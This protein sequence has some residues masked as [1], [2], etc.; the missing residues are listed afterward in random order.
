MQINLGLNRSPNKMSRPPE[1]AGHNERPID[2]GP[3]IVREM[4]AK[5]K[6]VFVTPQRTAGRIWLS[7]PHNVTEYGGPTGP[8]CPQPPPPSCRHHR[9]CRAA[10]ASAAVLLSPPSC[11][12]RNRRR[13]F[14]S[15]AA[16]L[17]PPPL[18]R[19]RQAAAS[20]AIAIV[21]I[22]V[23]VAVIVTVSATGRF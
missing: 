19:C 11:R 20:A 1:T 2:R 17:P 14:A 15:A 5:I 22:I 10:A 6:G 3:P 4:T 23:V 16:A 7:F 9:R 18:P 12:R 8:H 21:F 13:A